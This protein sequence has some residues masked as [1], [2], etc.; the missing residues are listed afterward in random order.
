[1]DLRDHVR[2]ARRSWWVIA[3]TTLAGLGLALGA[4]SLATPRWVSTAQVYVVV[5]TAGEATTGDLVQGGTAAHQKALAYVDIARTDRVLGPVVE[6]LGLDTS[7]RRLAEDVTA[8]SPEDTALISLEVSAPTREGARAVAD[9]ITRRLSA[10]VDEIE[11]VDDRGAVRMEIVQQ[12]D[13]P[14]A[15]SSPRPAADAALGLL[16]GLV[17]GVGVALLRARLDT[18]VRDVQGAADASGAPVLA[19][20]AFD[21]DIARRPL[22][23][24]D[25]PRDVR[26]EAYRTL[27]TNLRYSAVD[28]LVA[29]LVVTSAGQGEGKT[30]TACNL[31]LA[32]ADGGASVVL[33]DADLRRPQVAERMSLEGAVGL[34]DVL[35][36]RV[37]LDDVTQ[38]WGRSSL[39]VL[40]SGAIP[41]NPSE[42]LGSRGMVALLEHLA[43]R[44]DHVVVDAPPVLPVTDAALLAP[45]TDGALLVAAHGRTD[46]GALA[47]A[48]EALDR[49]QAR[50]VGTVLTMVPTKGPYDGG[51][52]SPYRYDVD[53]DHP[54]SSTTT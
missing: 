13:L 39:T 29:T 34:T 48:R 8:T 27:R 52:T 16:L 44:F 9:A 46:A 45:L 50:V 47:G 4:T 14:D 3:L 53:H 31:A 37:E 33:V 18:R 24:R 43:S 5:R 51:T 6:E 32:L 11:N 35:I 28:G 15:P 19:S 30:A 54:R 25:D 7:P 41:P 12:A 36:G 17:V 21:P 40:A 22:V 38:P 23:V 42:L 10:V 1:M 49:V 2:L 26:A 20:V